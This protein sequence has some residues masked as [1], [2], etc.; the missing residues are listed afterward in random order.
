MRSIWFLRTLALAGLTISVYLLALKLTGRISYLVGCGEGSGCA[1]VLGSRWSQFFHIPVTGLSAAMYAA[2]LAATWKPLKPVYA[3][4]AICFA[5]AAVWFCGIL[6]IDLKA[7]CP[8]CAAAHL[9][10]LTCSAGLFRALRKQPSMNGNVH[11]GIVGGIFAMLVF[12]LGQVAGPVPDTHAISTETVAAED[13]AVAVH[14][15]GEGR[16]V[17]VFEDRKSYNTSTLPHLG[18]ADAPH[19]VVK[20]FDF[21][22]ASCNDMHNDLAMVVRKHPGQFC[23]I[24]LPVPLNRACNQF[25]SPDIADH[26]HACELTRLAL[27]A[28]R[29]R[30]GAYP[31]VHEFL[32]TRPILTPDAART[33]LNGIVGEAALENAL[34]DPWVDEV[35]AANINDFRQLTAKTFKMPKLL[36]GKDRMLHGVTRTPGI[37]LRALEKEFNLPPAP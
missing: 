5:G 11:L 7:F 30:P 31:E 23:I 18:P 22:C 20:Y 26:P 17:S 13:A 27:A 29:A 14:A 15:R 2:L 16:V 6:V 12:I 34:A 32:F 9:V 4:L 1:N 25:F 36:V 28:W 24:M 35:L 8:W 37:L 19:V 10:G 21:T 33:G 3:G